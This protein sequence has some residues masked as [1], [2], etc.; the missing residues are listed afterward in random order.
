MDT[1][2]ARA[3]L[4]EVKTAYTNASPMVKAGVGHVVNPMVELL[5]GL[6][7]RTDPPSTWARGCGAAGC[8]R[9]GGQMPGA[10]PMGLESSA[11]GVLHGTR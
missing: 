5:N 2:T 9:C 8:G 11:R 10:D 4:A 1:M 3:K 6:I 7:E